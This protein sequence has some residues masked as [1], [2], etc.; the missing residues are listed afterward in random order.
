MLVSQKLSVFFTI[1]LL[2]VCMY[3]CISKSICEYAT[4]LLSL[5]IE[6]RPFL[7]QRNQHFD[8]FIFLIPF[9]FLSLTCFKFSAVGHFNYQYARRCWKTLLM[10]ERHWKLINNVFIVAKLGNICCGRKICPGHKNVFEFRQ[11][12]CLFPSSKICLRNI[13]FPRG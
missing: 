4:S 2:Y 9:P 1:K 3:V 11:K 7:I 12:H 6:T 8:L 13:C 10:S 5:S